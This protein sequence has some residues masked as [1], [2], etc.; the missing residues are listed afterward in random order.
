MPEET[1]LIQPLPV[2]RDAYGYWTHPAWPS[3]EHELIPYA[4]FDSRGLEAR[5]LAF[6]YD[7]SEEVQ[8][9]WLAEGI[10]DC[11]AW[12]PTNPHG[13]GWFIFSIHD[14]EDGP[15]CVWVRQAVAS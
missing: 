5:E 14:T 6:E 7:A 8:A 15:I 13:E 10:A 3:T 9:S 1:V 11:A 12:H 4:W 2:E